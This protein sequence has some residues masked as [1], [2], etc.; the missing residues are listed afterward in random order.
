MIELDHLRIELA[1]RNLIEA[2]AGT[3]KTY[4]IACLY[5]RLVIEKGLPPDQILVVT[6]TEAATEELRGRIRTRLREALEVFS[7]A[8]TDDLILQGLVD[9]VNG[10]GPTPA[11]ALDR[12]NLAIRSFDLASIFTIHGFCL[13]ALQ[14]HAFESGSPYDTEL[15][16]DQSPLLQE[17][18]DDFW[19]MK[20]FA[21]PAPL[22]GYALRSGLSPDYFKSFLMGMLGNP[23]LRILPTYDEGAVEALEAA[24]QVSYAAVAAGWRSTRAGVIALI[25]TDKNLKRAAGFY[26]ADLLPAYSDAMD[27]YLSGGNPY[28]ILPGIERFSTSGIVAGTKEKTGTPP[29]HP[30]FELCEELAGKVHERFLALRWELIAFARQRLPARKRESNIRFFDDLLTDLHAALGGKTGEQFAVCLREKYRAALIDEFQDT[31]PV[32]YDIF[33]RIYAGPD[34]LLFLIGDPKQAI[35]SFRGADI[36]AYLEAAADV[37]HARCFTLTGNWRSSPQLL[38]AFNRIFDNEGRPFVFDR[39]AYHPVRSGNETS[40]RKFEFAEADAAPLQLWLVPPGE[41]CG[42]LMIGDANMLIPAAVAAEIG[43]LLQAGREGKALVDGRSVLPEDMAVI[44]RDHWQAGYTQ[45]AL[46][47]LGIPSVMRSDRSLFATDEAREVSTL[48]AALADP[49]NETKVRTALV[50]DLLGKSGDDL[51]LLLGRE[52]EWDDRLQTFRDYHQTWLERGFMVMSQELL[53]GEGVRGRLLRRP[54]GE[55]RL[56]NL[57]HC[58]EVIHRAAHE[59]R[60]GIE[61]QVTWFA[62]RVSGGEAAEEYQIRLETDE[63]A[64][65]IVTVHV[66]KGLEYSIVFCPFLWG[67]IKG[68]NEVLTFHDEFSVVKDFGSPDYDRHRVLARKEALAESLRLLYVALTRAKFRCYLVGGKFS[69]KTRRNRPETSPL[70]YLFHTAKETK[71]ADD[72]VSLQEQEVKALSAALMQEQ[73]EAF[74]VHG[75]G[76]IAVLSLPLPVDAVPYLP[77]GGDATVLRCRKFKGVIDHTWRVSSFT[78]FAAHEALESEL[79]DRDRT[80]VGEAVPVSAPAAE[81]PQAKSIFTFPRGARAG[82]FLHEIFEKIDFASGYT[83]KVTETVSEC[84]KK[85]NFAAEWQDPVCTM[86][87]N[88]LAMPLG[89][90]VDP[91][92]LADL[93]QGSWLVELEFFFPLKFVT[94]ET[95]RDCF[96]RWNGNSSAVDLTSLCRSLR[97]RPAQGIMRGFMDL[98]FEHA[99]RYYLLDWKSNHLGNRVEEYGQAALKTAMESNLYPLQYLLYTVALNKHLSLRV[100][101]YDYATHFGGVRYLFLRGI[102]P[103]RGNE[104][105]V[106]SDVPPAELIRDLTACLIEVER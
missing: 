4:A 89:P 3:G 33:R 36:F 23:A 66:S 41:D 22:L 12:L 40:A 90:P 80:G 45:E 55:R 47:T 87:G 8:G 88:V 54:D 13:R 14:D 56:T 37:D 26:R 86:I 44:V 7:G 34:A 71:A 43:R 32:Q 64:V 25:A 53:S 60:L 30:F 92:T 72:L 17:I 46:R 94:S 31:D 82:I 70:A 98:V 1:G 28:E 97:F 42:G 79:P 39:I 96:R 75:A 21:E 49:G 48:L 68:G 18:V 85:H 19:R 58:F 93:R 2:S 9:N 106:F 11:I 76:E 20:F 77:K 105:G 27:D 38:A 10:E 59:R 16:T 15:I 50:T 84:L 91:F 104:Y 74:A 63:K 51:A 99:G 35:Y 103:K 65:K 101:G 81:E 73:L 83:A 67:G 5:L 78:S 24:C 61:G 62:E 29:V 95:L 6:Y 102:D 52:Q 69:D 100:K 57:L